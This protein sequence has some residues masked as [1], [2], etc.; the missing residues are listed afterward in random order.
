MSELTQEQISRRECGHIADQLR[1][2]AGHMDAY[3][4]GSRK[5]HSEDCK[6]TVALSHYVIRYLVEQW[7]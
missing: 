2:L 4:N 1:R 3:A 7:M 6:A 5:L